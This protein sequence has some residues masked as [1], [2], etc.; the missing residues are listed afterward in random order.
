MVSSVGKPDDV[1]RAVLEINRNLGGTI[2]LNE[3]LG[4]TLDT[5]FA[6]FREAECGFIVTKEA[7][8]ELSPRAIRHRDGDPD[9]LTLS[10]TA[11]DHVMT[12]GA[13]AAQRR[14]HEPGSKPGIDLSSVTRRG[15]SSAC[16]DAQPGRPSRSGS[17]SSS[18]RPGPP[19]IPRPTGS[20][21]WPPWPCR[22]P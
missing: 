3:A 13:G 8:G 1:L 21:C 11:L 6:I 7:D 4:K 18:A 10:Q 16:P 9:P 17:S 14:I 5:L 2:E 20:T 15:R 22:S 19:R 12:P